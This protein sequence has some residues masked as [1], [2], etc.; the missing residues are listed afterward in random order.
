MSDKCLY[1]K[2][3]SDSE[4]ELIHLCHQDRNMASMEAAVKTIAVAVDEIKEGQKEVT[5]LMRDI[6]VQGEKVTNIETRLD[7]EIRDRKHVNE[8]LFDRVHSLETAP[9][10]AANSRMS[11]LWSGVI[12]AAAALI[13][14]LV[15]RAWK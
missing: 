4:R 8:I 2:A 3:I 10:V 6:A 12:A 13:V 14:A 1:Q 7:G 9:V 5:K 11:G 15:A